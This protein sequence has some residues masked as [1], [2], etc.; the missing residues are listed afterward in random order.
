MKRTETWW[1]P[2]REAHGVALTARVARHPSSQQWVVTVW[3][4]VVLLS[5]VVV[6]T[7]VAAS[8][9]LCSQGFKTEDQAC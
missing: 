2:T 8:Q 3:A 1:H 9:W 7:R 6:A 5:S 4:G